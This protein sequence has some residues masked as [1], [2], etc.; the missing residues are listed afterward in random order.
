MSLSNLSKYRTARFA[1]FLLALLGWSAFIT[2]ANAA[3]AEPVVLQLKWRHAFQFAGYYAALEK[4]YYR[5]A[6]F[7]VVLQELESSS[8]PLE[9][10]L[11]GQADFAV[12]GADIVI[13][14]AQG[15]PVVALATIFQHSPYA[16]L[17]RADS[18]ISRIEDFAGKRIM[19][20][21][22]YQSADLQV[23]LKRA[24]LSPTQFQRIPTNFDFRS[25]LRNES[26]AFDAYLTD[27]GQSMEE[28]GVAG[29]YILPNQYGVD[30]YGD[31][32]ATTESL[33]RQSPEKVRAFREASLKG[34]T[35]A[36][37]HIDEMIDMILANY[38]TQG[39][40]R[41]HLHYE[42]NVTREMIL[43]F[44]V[45]I[46][47]MNNERWQDI[48]NVFI[49]GNFL[50]K[51]STIDGL[52]FAATVTPPTFATW[53][54]RHLPEIIIAVVS[55]VI[56]ALLLG[57]VIMKR[58]LAAGTEALAANEKLLSTVIK[59]SPVCVKI[60]DDQGQLLMM[61]EAGL[62]ML[63]ASSIEQIN[64]KGILN[65][66]ERPFQHEFLEMNARVFKGES[67]SILFPIS[68]FKGNSRWLESHAVPLRNPDG[69]TRVLGI[70][71]DVSDRILMESALKEQ[72]K[73]LQ[74]LL[75]S[76]NG[77]SWEYDIPSNRFTFV[78]PNSYRLS[79]YNPVEWTDSDFWA[80]LIVT[81]DRAST[82]L[83]R[84]T[85]T[86][87][88]ID[89]MLEYRLRKRSGEII[90]VLEVVR[91]IMGA[92]GI[93][94]S[95]AGFII[96]QTSVKQ[97]ELAVQESEARY[98]SIIEGAPE[99]VWLLDEKLK[100][101]A[102]ND[103]LLT[104]LGVDQ[105]TLQSRSFE[106]YLAPG[107]IAPAEMTLNNSTLFEFETRLLRNDGTPIPVL[108]SVSRLPPGS[109]GYTPL[110][111][112]VRDLTQQKQS[113]QELR[114]AQKMEALG[115]LTGGIAHDFNN[116]LGI[117]LGNLE[118]LEPELQTHPTARPRVMELQQATH[119]AISLTQQLLGF[120][121]NKSQH[122]TACNLNTLILSFR[123]FIERSITPSILVQYQLDERLDDVHIDA[124]DF[125]GALLN[126]VINARDA[127]P[128]GGN[129][130]IATAN[131]TIDGKQQ[132]QLTISDTGIGISKEAQDRVF[133]PFFTTKEFGK[134]TGLGLAI[135]FGF[136]Q[137]SGGTIEVLSDGHSGTSFL[138]TFPSIRQ[139]Q[140]PEQ[141][142]ITRQG[143][144][145][146][147]IILAVDD[148][149]SL[150]ELTKLRLDRLG[151]HTLIANNAGS[152]LE[153]LAA[154]PSI[155]LLFTDVVMPGSMNGYELAERALQISPGLKVLHTSGFAEH[156]QMRAEHAHFA[157]RLLKKPYSL[158]Q[159][160]DC[161]QNLLPA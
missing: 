8:S 140:S 59:A 151:Y 105:K 83:A 79:G 116:I 126:L 92:E 147:K 133:E 61:N 73:K 69:E 94:R 111:A 97:A 68:T 152:A 31:V 20:G 41:E 118:L 34:W 93:P 108:V 47:Y 21:T 87:A 103:R 129:L 12:T 60:V 137:R 14:R 75:D 122:S 154:N 48:L 78:S 54:A 135:V 74:N 63:D 82:L 62:S 11:A 72:H 86:K 57:L 22:G 50:P 125:Q 77:I 90:W 85:H 4:G 155:D 91:V 145:D 96:D 89:H 100:T 107:A 115:L 35:Y 109:D 3:Q 40:T 114:R 53:I 71:M 80:S 10:M 138:M 46:G 144:T 1:L 123:T 121:R 104:L 148:E 130:L 98:R 70:T 45:E 161:I 43:P 157:A 81:E 142:Q 19:L 134:G 66:V 13:Q 159:L 25:L 95:L 37:N 150:L 6:G 102:C 131:K 36:L 16:F 38:N 113:E 15:A 112:F 64:Q 30:F 65:L 23:A 88:G 119:R 67:A 17:V 51:D 33:A 160:Q 9:I 149:E 99:G 5:E 58:R 49:E 158:Q 24:G 18:G 7:E 136:V 124:G 101:L 28:A 128:N 55:A 110:V 132:V 139:Q 84:D 117:M 127:M 26:D 39:L 146:K 141:P 44:L 52:M 2:T 29:R 42:A 32:L 76:V 120:S 56:L 27:Q 143:P 153:L 106:N 156:A